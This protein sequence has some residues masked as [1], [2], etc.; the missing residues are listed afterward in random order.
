MEPADVIQLFQVLDDI[1]LVLTDVKVL[2]EV[3]ISGT[4]L[5]TGLSIVFGSREVIISEDAMQ[6]YISMRYAW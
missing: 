6:P 2:I 3:V 1:K 4:F 5:L